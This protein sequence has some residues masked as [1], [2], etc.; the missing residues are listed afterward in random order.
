MATETIRVL[1]VED[2]PGDARLLGEALA[3]AE[4]SAFHLTNVQ[5]LART[6]VILGEETFDLLLLDLGLPDS[7]GLDPLTL[8]RAHAPGA[9]IVVLT[10]L[11]DESLAIS[12]LQMGAQ[13]Y[14]VKGQASG[15]SLVRS[16]R[17]AIERNRAE[18]RMQ[19]SLAEKEAQLSELQAALRR[20]EL[21]LNEAVLGQP[22]SASPEKR[23]LQ[24]LYDHPQGA[25]FDTLQEAAEVSA[26]V[27]VVAMA[28]LIDTGKV[29]QAF[30]LFFAVAQPRTSES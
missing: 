22:G 25:G 16:L 21:R 19:T 9:A 10:G 4:E 6:L 15:K 2:N 30:P 23:V 26:R 18:A 28:T 27:I 29:R 5:T 1:L 8:V 7:Q 24:Y 3:E 11:E 12:A 13:D 17:H 14:L 20:S